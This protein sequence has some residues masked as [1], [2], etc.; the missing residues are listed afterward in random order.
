MNLPFDNWCCLSLLFSFFFIE[1]EIPPKPQVDKAATTAV[2]IEKPASENTNAAKEE[3]SPSKPVDK[4]DLHEQPKTSSDTK[5]KEAT[6]AV[7]IE[8]PASENT[9]AAKVKGSPSKPVDKK[10]LHEKSAS[11]TKPKDATVAV[12]VEKPTSKSATPSKEKDLSKPIDKKELHKKPKEASGKEIAESEKSDTKTKPKKGFKR[13]FRKSKS[14]D[15][16]KKSGKT[17]PKSKSG[18][19]KDK[20]KV[21]KQHF[22]LFLSIFKIYL[23]HLPSFLIYYPVKVIKMLY[24]QAEVKSISFKILQVTLWRCV[25]E[26][27]IY[28]CLSRPNNFISI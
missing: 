3:G 21:D 11:E 12:E 22:F 23:I 2:E 18:K 24:T 13:F 1:K 7:E 10:D 17:D 5:P 25:K 6:T 9:N 27:L 15:D 19:G 8:K 20:K 16:K 26:K 4:D 14:S 28:F